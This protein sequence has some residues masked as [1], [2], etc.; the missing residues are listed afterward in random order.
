MKL[1]EL[2]DLIK[3]LCPIEGVNSSGAIWFKPEATP[4][5]REAAEALMAQMLPQLDVEAF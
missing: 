2:D 4:E 1:Y 5:Q 3:T